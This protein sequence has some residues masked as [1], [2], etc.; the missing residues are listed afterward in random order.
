MKIWVCKGK[1]LTVTGAAWY[2]LGFG[3]KTATSTWASPCWSWGTWKHDFSATSLGTH[4]WPHWGQHAKLEGGFQAPSHRWEQGTAIQWNRAGWPRPCE[5]S[6]LAKQNPFYIQTQHW[7][8]NCWVKN[9]N[10]SG[11]DQQRQR[12]E[13]SQEQ[14][15]WGSERTNYRKWEACFINPMKRAET[16]AVD[17]WR[18]EELSWPNLLL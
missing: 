5:L 14:W 7:E 8:E 1:P 10:W 12:E 3:R 17:S 15:G 16:R 11:P 6:K 13:K 4:C 9:P 18:S 2:Q